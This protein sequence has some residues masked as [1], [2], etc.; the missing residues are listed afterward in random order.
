M[1]YQ[2]HLIKNRRLGH[3]KKNTKSLWLGILSY[4]QTDA[5]E[6]MSVH[7]DLKAMHFW[8]ASALPNFCL[9]FSRTTSSL[10]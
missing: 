1:I 3:F 2:S 5:Y 9:P 10:H 4:S 6:D 8:I 7:L